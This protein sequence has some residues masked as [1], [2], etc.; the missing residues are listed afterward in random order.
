MLIS[1]NKIVMVLVFKIFLSDCSIDSNLVKNSF[2]LS[3]GDLYTQIKF[4][5]TT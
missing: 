4:I 5:G 2:T 1:L 3:E